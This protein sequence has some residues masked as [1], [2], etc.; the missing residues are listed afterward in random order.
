MRLP[1][2]LSAGLLALCLLSCAEQEQEIQKPDLDYTKP[3]AADFT[4]AKKT[5]Q[6]P[7]VVFTEIARDA[8]IA[9]RHETG[10]AG[11]K[12]MPETMGSGVAL[13]DYDESGRARAGMGIDIAY[14]DNDGVPAIAIGNFSREGLSLYPYSQLWSGQTRAGGPP[15]YPLARRH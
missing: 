10:A 1:T 7:K 11:N 13:F 3:T 4:S 5:K 8:G 9:F 6:P 14:L 12:W 2:W 15:A